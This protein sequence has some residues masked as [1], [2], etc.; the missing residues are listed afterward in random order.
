MTL[1]AQGKWVSWRTL[2]G[3]DMFYLGIDVS[4]AK[5]E[6]CLLRQDV[7]DKRKSKVFAN[8]ASGVADL[9]R[10]LGKQG[11]LPGNT[12]ALLEAT[13]GVSRIGGHGTSRER[14][15]R[16]PPQSGAGQGFWQGI[17]VAHPDG[18]RRPLAVGPFRAAPAPGRLAARTGAGQGVAGAVEPPT[19]APG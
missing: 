8:S 6:G 2:K 12:H 5:L 4:K 15:H 10:W 7:P 18:C 9:L 19:G 1:D 14:T 16:V 13:G 17:G 3:E 11:A